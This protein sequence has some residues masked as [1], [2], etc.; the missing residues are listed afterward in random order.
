MLHRGGNTDQARRIPKGPFS[1][2]LL[3]GYPQRYISFPSS[4]I[5]RL[6]DEWRHDRCKE[7]QRKRKKGQMAAGRSAQHCLTSL[8]FLNFLATVASNVFLAQ[9]PTCAGSSEV[10]A[11]CSFIY[12]GQQRSNRLSEVLGDAIVF[13]LTGKFYPHTGTLLSS[14]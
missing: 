14:L 12:G 10:I 7:K 13:Q 5:K 2:G 1:R 8:E 11:C 3:L 9:A 6:P 4:P